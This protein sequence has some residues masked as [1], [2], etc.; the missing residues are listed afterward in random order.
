MRTDRFTGP[1]TFIDRTIKSWLAGLTGSQ[2][3]DFIEVVF[4]AI[5]RSG[6]SDFSHFEMVSLPRIINLVWDATSLELESRR[7]LSRVLLGIMQASGLSVL[8]TVK[9]S[10]LLAK[11]ALLGLF[12][13]D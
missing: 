4:D 5:L 2:R 6:I 10:G 11:D 8:T 3:K 12:T 9:Q 13:N 7:N 1:S